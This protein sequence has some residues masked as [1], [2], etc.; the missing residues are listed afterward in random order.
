MPLAEKDLVVVEGVPFLRFIPTAAAAASAGPELA[1]VGV[2]RRSPLLS[3]IMRSY[4][5][6][7]QC[8][9]SLFSKPALTAHHVALFAF[10]NARAAISSAAALWLRIT[11][12]RASV[13]IAALQ[14][15][16]HVKF[17][18]AS[19]MSSSTSRTPTASRCSTFR[20]LS[21]DAHLPTPLSHHLHH[22]SRAVSENSGIRNS[23]RWYTNTV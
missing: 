20:I 12:H 17:A 18:V 10:K 21:C 5:S 13:L 7:T 3:V 16:L 22:L 23:A 19:M 1:N 6:A 11:A 15:A 14:N 8:V 4:R 9:K 2:L